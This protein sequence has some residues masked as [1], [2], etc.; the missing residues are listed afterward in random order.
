MFGTTLDSERA[1]AHDDTMH[2][3]YV[4]RRV[5]ALVLALAAVAGL[6]GRI[7][8]AAG[9]GSVELVASRTYVV[10]PG[11]TLWSIAGDIAPQRDP[12]VVV[13]ELT[14]LNPSAGERLV[15]GAVLGLP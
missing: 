8:A 12:R 1:F 2:R 7:A 4:R 9:S 6:S 15:P 11:D 14:T 5:V 10:R 13:H 3:T